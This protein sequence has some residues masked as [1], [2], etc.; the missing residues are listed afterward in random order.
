M[1]ISLAIKQNGLQR[2][3]LITCVDTGFTLYII[4]MM[5]KRATIYL[6]CGFWFD[7]H[8]LWLKGGNL[9]TEDF[10]SLVQNH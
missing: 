8:C 9:L 10:F 1:L 4:S 2:G 6:L 5:L 7:L 3:F